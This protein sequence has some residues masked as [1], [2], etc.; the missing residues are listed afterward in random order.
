MRAKPDQPDLFEPD[1]VYALALT[2]HGLL[3]TASRKVAE[4]WEPDDQ[5][6]AS[7]LLARACE[8]AGMG[9]LSAE[10]LATTITGYLG[11]WGGRYSNLDDDV[12]AARAYLNSV[13]GGAGEAGD[14]LIVPGEVTLG[15]DH[16]A[17]LIDWWLHRGDAL[18]G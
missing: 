3:P 4:P 2:L 11:G 17:I 13:V 14:V 16:I 12:E 10:I 18:E 9:T 7:D 15:A 5:Y 8:D 1:G 6:A